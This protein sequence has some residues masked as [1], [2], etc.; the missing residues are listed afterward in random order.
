MEVLKRYLPAE[1]AD[2][3]LAALVAEIVARVGATGPR[4]MGKVMPLALKE[5]GDRV[6]GKRLSD[7][8]RQALTS[9]G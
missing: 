1:M 3:E 7:A 8:V 6:S 9:Q 4:D 5:A 2:D